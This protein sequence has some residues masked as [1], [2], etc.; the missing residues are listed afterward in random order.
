MGARTTTDRICYQTKQTKGDRHEMTE[1][2][3]DIETD[4]ETKNQP[5]RL[6]N[7]QNHLIIDKFPLPMLFQEVVFPSRWC[8]LYW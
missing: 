2:S 3:N 5:K 6:G 8:P 4:N 7:D 1:K